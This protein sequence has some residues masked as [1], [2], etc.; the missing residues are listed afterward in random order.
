MRKILSAFVAAALSMSALPAAASA[1]T[2]VAYSQCRAGGP[3]TQ[4]NAIAARV[5][6]SLTGQLRGS[7]T[8]ERVS[9]A[10]AIARATAATAFTKPYGKQA[11]VIAVTTAIV[12]ST[13]I[14]HTESTD[15]DSLGLF[16]Q[17]ASWGSAA[18]R[19]NPAWATGAFLRK[20]AALYPDQSWRSAPIGE[21]CQAVQVS[22]F[23]DRYQVQVHDA[24]LIVDAVWSGGGVS[25]DVTGNGWDDILARNASDDK[26]YLYDGFAPGKLASPRAMGTGWGAT[27]IVLT[28]DFT[29]DTEGD[30]LGITT[31]GDMNLYTGN[32]STFSA[33]KLVGTGWNSMKFVVTADFTGEGTNDLIGIQ[34]G[35]GDLYFYAGNGNGTFSAPRKLASGWGGQ[36]AL[37]AGD[38]DDDNHGDLVG[39]AANGD[40]NQYR[41][42]GNAQFSAPAKFSNGWNGITALI[43]GDFTGDGKTDIAGRT[44][45]G[46]LNLYP[47]YGTTLGS[48]VAL[49]TGWN[50]HN[51]YQS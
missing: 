26:L 34:E 17:R 19:T 27:R 50:G 38:F 11:A 5:N 14:N 49:G 2:E 16:E 32:G 48:G 42:Y 9:C 29:G 21:V 3:S 10:S 43:P 45:D 40:L 13:L 36:T 25:R 30:L 31:A 51:L 44:A 39:R 37:V 12:E 33:P 20:M 47:S 1:S 41:G 46:T 24:Q 6:P 18:E 15:H 28:G 23:P 35:S 22:A 7:L 8:G 4:D